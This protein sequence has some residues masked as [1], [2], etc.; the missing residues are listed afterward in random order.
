[1]VVAEEKE[2]EKVVVMVV[3][4]VGKIVL[5]HANGSVSIAVKKVI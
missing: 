5:H 4:V 2:K 3:A 1:M